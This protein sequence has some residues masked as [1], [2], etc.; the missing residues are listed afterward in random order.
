MT[1]ADDCPYCEYVGDTCPQ[2]EGRNAMTAGKWKWLGT[3]GRP[4][5]KVYLQDEAGKQILVIFDGKEPS[6]EHAQ[7]IVQAVNSH[8]EL[9]KALEAAAQMADSWERN[10]KIVF[11]ALQSKGIPSSDF[12]SWDAKI[13]R[14]RAALTAAGK[15]GKG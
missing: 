4:N 15:G 8:S 12:A 9:V 5:A 6:D 13:A 11:A 1:E 7:Q 2:C 14:I 10:K 3:L